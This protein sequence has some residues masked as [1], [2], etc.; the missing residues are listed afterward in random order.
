[1]MRTTDTGILS[2]CVRVANQQLINCKSFPLL[3]DG[4]D[5]IAFALPIKAKI[6]GF[7]S[8]AGAVATDAFA[9]IPIVCAV[10]KYPVLL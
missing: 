7:L 8:F 9:A 1:M 6:V 4:R 2:W 10:S 5:A 3:I